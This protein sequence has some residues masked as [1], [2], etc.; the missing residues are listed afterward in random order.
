[1]TARDDAV[2][3]VKLLGATAAKPAVSDG[4]VGLAVDAYG[5]VD[6]AGVPPNLIGWSPTYDVNAAVAEVYRIKAGLVS[7]DFNFTADDASFSKGDVLA[8]LLSMEAK[9]AAMAVTANNGM[10]TGNSSGTIQVGGTN[11]PYTASLDQIAAQVIP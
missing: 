11:Y 8:N 4:T 3:R 7:S 10:T 5:L 1:M 2:A 6:A 9:Y